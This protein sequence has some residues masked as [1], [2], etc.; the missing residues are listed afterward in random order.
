MYRF[1]KLSASAPESS[2]HFFSIEIGKKSIYFLTGFNN[3]ALFNIYM[4][5]QEKSLRL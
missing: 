4:L 2:Q 3:I 1:K 5:Q